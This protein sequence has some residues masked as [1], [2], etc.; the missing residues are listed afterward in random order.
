ME[1]SNLF[2][3]IGALIWSLLAL[4]IA[5]KLGFFN[6]SSNKESSPTISVVY[7]LAA[8]ALF[9]GVQIIFSVFFP[10]AKWRDPV[11]ILTTWFA[12]RIYL[13]LFP[14]VK[15][16]VL[17]PE[18]FISYR[19]SYYNFFLGMMTWLLCY[20]LVMIINQT[21]S[22]I[23]F[24]LFE[25]PPI[26]QLSVELMKGYLDNPFYFWIMAIIIC[27]IVPAIEELLFRGYLQ[28]K[29][30]SHLGRTYAIGITSLIFSLFHYAP[31]QGLQNIS[32][33]TALF[34]LSCFLGYLNERQRTLY[35]P[36]GL[37]S[38]FNAISI[39][40]IFFQIE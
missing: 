7:V 36:I 23:L 1:E 32:V 15:R 5:G 19:H 31:E 10:E 20:P 27:T 39:L 18:T 11:S 38:A 24:V 13:K 9:L 30:K 40:M 22:L 2:G 14:A 8:F 26:D 4:S 17:G 29:L 16:I 33:L 3:I 37:H 35:A 28:T 21:I 25:K 6:I 12:L 34:V